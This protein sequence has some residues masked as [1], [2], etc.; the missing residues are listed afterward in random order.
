M[1]GFVVKSVLRKDRIEGKILLGKARR[2]CAPCRRSQGRV[3]L[4][5]EKR[6][7]GRK[8]LICAAEAHI[9]SS[10]KRPPPRCGGIMRSVGK[11]SSS[12][13]PALCGRMSSAASIALPRTDG[14]RE[15]AKAVFPHGMRVGIPPGDILTPTA[16]PACSCR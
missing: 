2:L 6:A 4:G 13:Y 11:A 8:G 12:S 3:R 15:P 5:C 1:E 9:S 14:V 10:R 7:L 16:N